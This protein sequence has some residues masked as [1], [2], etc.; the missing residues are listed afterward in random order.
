M[1]GLGSSNL[2]DHEI[3]EDDDESGVILREKSRWKV[4]PAAI[5]M[6]KAKLRIAFLVLFACGASFLLFKAIKYQVR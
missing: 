1:R 6:V 4:S 5:E 3:E 2:G